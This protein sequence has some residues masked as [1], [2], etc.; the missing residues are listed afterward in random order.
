MAQELAASSPPSGTCPN[1]GG[2]EFFSC[3]EGDVCRECGYAW[4]TDNWPKD[5][6]VDGDPSVGEVGDIEAD[7]VSASEETDS[8]VG[9][10]GIGRIESEA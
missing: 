9:V 5:G 1:C 10:D 3:D 4:P 6:D 2:D 7:L 8:T